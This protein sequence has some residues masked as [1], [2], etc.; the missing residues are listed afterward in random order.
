MK[1]PAVLVSLLSL[2][3]CDMP[4][5]PSAEE[6]PRLGV[7]RTQYSVPAT[8]L[9]MSILGKGDSDGQRIIFVHGTPG[10]ANGW[11]RFLAKPAPGTEMLAVDRPGFGATRPAEAVTSLKEQAAALEPLL[12]Q[13]GGRWPILV[14]HS[15]GGPIVAQLALDHPRRVEALVILA[16]SFD[17]G[18]EEV[19]AVQRVG[20]WPGVRSLVPTT[21]R[22]ANRELIALEP[23]LRLLA[24]RLHD[25]RCRV[26]VVH[27][28]A[29]R[30]VPFANV[31]FLRDRIADGQL[32]ITV[33]EGG[34][35]F[36]P[37]ERQPLVEQV[38][39][40]LRASPGLPC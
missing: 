18:L 35:H 4:E 6:A 10:D 23:Q 20:E 38:I 3:G 14:G 21:L 39:G 32:G 17:P 30:Q 19:L 31:A 22:N 25:L 27:G 33:I 26:E 34:N 15:L 36:I 29:D 9:V 24:P 40:R 16:G 8:N 11:V 7:H 12:R 37:W 5:T 13:R 28:T 1:R 2:V